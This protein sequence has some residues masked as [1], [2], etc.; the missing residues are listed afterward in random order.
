MLFFWKKKQETKDFPDWEDLYKNQ[1][2]KTMP[3]YYELLDADFEKEIKQRK[4]KGT[5]L[6]IGT[7]SGTQ[8]IELAK[9]GLNVTGI[10]ISRSAVEKAKQLAKKNKI[11]ANFQFDDI[12]HSSMLPDYFD[13]AFD[14]GCFHCIMPEQR[15]HYVDIL[16]NL[17]KKNRTLFLKT[18]STKE[19][20][21]DGPHRFSEEEIRNIFSK[22]FEIISIKESQFQGSR[23]AK[24]IFCILKKK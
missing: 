1:D 16:H 13:Y 14:R 22:K 11:N 23:N 19:T 4:M 7:G 5:V 21:N 6:D 12:L 8:A 3:W 18:F 20:G 24:A 17:L 2:V 15:A 10:D 9:L